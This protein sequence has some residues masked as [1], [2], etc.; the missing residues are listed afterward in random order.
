MSRATLA[1]VRRMVNE[2]LGITQGTYT[3]PVTTNKRYPAGYI[4]DAIAGA[5]LTV[6]KTLL[7]SKQY[8]FAPDFFTVQSIPASYSVV[9]LPVNTEMLN[10]RFYYNTSGSEEQGVEIPWEMFEMFT[11]PLSS[12][13]T[14]LFSFTGEGGKK[15]GGY[16]SVKDHTLWTIPFAGVPYKIT[17]TSATFQI[18]SPIITST[19]TI[20][21]EGHPFVSGDRVIV[22]TTGTFPQVPDDGGE[23]TP[24]AALN[25][26]T[27]YTVENNDIDSFFLFVP[28]STS[29][30]I[31]FGSGG[32]GVLT[33]T[34]VEENVG[35]F[36]YIS[37]AHQSTLTTLYSPKSFEEAIAFLASA[38]L[39][40]KRADNPNQ[41]TYY[42]QQYQAM[43]GIY[44]T[45]SSNEQRTIDQ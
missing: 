27:V 16:Y 34:K 42:L 18:E 29:E 21:S 14:S 30:Y 37:L 3:T 45:P 8:H 28:G 41:A 31:E 24:A 19:S 5:D 23:G 32:T 38:N 4:D 9:E 11:E 35:Y 22:S 20:V 40:M 1:T 33:A 10:V 6:M 17:G 44:M 26:T 43:M 39:L 2:N 36:K 12:T 25:S 15:Y 13:G 7:K